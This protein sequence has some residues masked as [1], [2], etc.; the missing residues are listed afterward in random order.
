MSLIFKYLIK[1]YQKFISRFTYGSCRFYPSCSEYAIWQFENNS[2]F[3]G[4]YFTIT[5]ILKCNQLF[6]GGID[7]PVVKKVPFTNI[8]FKKVKVKSWFIP[9]KDNKYFVVKNWERNKNN[10]QQQ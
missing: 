5:R 4:I 10:E 6:N 1:F 8:L 7:D 9:I 2:F 3:K